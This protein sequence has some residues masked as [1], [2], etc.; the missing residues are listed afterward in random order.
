[1]W[2]E[3]F[4]RLKQSASKNKY[5]I[6]NSFTIDVAVIFVENY[7]K[8][9]NKIKKISH[10]IKQLKKQISIEFHQ[11][12]NRWNYQAANK[13]SSHREWDHHI[14]LK[15]EVVSLVKKTY[16]LSR[17]QTQMIKQ[18][19]DEM[20]EKDFIRF[21]KFDY[22]ILVLIIKKL[23]EDLRVCVNYRALN[24]L[25]IKNRNASSLIR[26]TLTR[27]C[28]IRIYSKFDIIAAFNEVRM[29]E[30]DEKKIVFLTR[31]D[32]FEY[33]VMSFE[34][35]NAFE[36]FQSFINNT[37]REYLNDFYFNYLDD[38]L[39]FSNFKKEHI[40]HVRKVLKRLKEINLFLNIDKCEFFVISVKYLDLIITIDDIKMNSQKIETIVNWK[41]SKCVK[42]VQI[43][44]DF[45]NFYRKF[46]FD[47]FRLAAS[48]SKL[49]KITEI[50]F[51]YSWNLEN[52]EKAIFRTLKLVFIIV[53]ILQ[54]FNSNLKTWIETDVFD[55]IVVAILSQRDIDEQL[56]SV[57]YMS[58]KMSSVECNYEIYDKKL[59]AIVK[60]FEKWKSEC[61]ETSIEDSVKI[62]IDHKNLEHF[63]SFKQLNRRQTKWTE[64]LAKFNFKIAYRSNVQR[65]K[66]DNLTRRSQDL[67][68]N[69]NDERQQYN[70]RILLKAHYLKSEVRKAIEM[71]LA[72]MNER[73]ETVASLAVML[74]DLSEKKFETDEKSTVESSA[75]RHLEDDSIEEKSTEEFSIDTFTAQS[76]IMT[77]IIVVYSNDDN[78]QKIIEVKRQEL[79][80]ISADII[81]TEI[82]LKFDDCEIRKNDLLWIKNRL[83]VLEDEELH[84]V[85]LKQFHDAS[86]SDHADR[87]ITYD[88]L[89]THYYWFRML[90]TIFRYVKSCTQCK[91]IKTY[92]QDKQDLLKSLSI[93]ERYFQNISVDFITSLF[94]CTRYDRVYKHIMIVIDRLS[95]KKKFISLKSLEMK[96]V[97]QVFLKWIW[98][99][100]D[101]SDSIVSNRKTQFISHFWRRLCERINIKSKLST[102]WHFEIDDQIENVN[103]DLKVYLRVYVNFNQ[104]NWIN[105][106]SIVE[107]EV[108]FVINSSTDMT[109]FLATKEYLSKS[110][111]KSLTLITDNVI[112]KREM[113]DVDKFI[114]HQEKLREFLRNELI[115]TQVKQEEQINKRRHVVSEL[116][117]RNKVMLDSRYISIIRSNRE[118]NYKNLDS[119][120]I[121]RA[122][123]NSV[124]ELNLS[125]SMK[126]VFSVFHLWLL[127]LKDDDSLSKQE[128][129]EFD[130]IATDV[131]DNELW[132][133]EKILKFKIDMR[134]ID[135][136]SQQRDA[137]DCLYYYV[138]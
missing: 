38:I 82:R 90:H 126:R 80:R 1:M 138:K 104:N 66:S 13:L 136:E 29:R 42:N 52:S 59:L 71:T 74:Y 4:E 53:L 105:L 125:K 14:D 87:A 130:L 124:Y 88:R 73:E 2:S 133:T 99:E 39:I 18:Y 102:V 10:T 92:R 78:L 54:H 49:T 127:H 33:V 27:L 112:Q 68:E 41:S 98:R 122:I 40:E 34:L 46:I 116:R 75:E 114:Q 35:C 83:Y 85:I 57:I 70:H 86:I 63:M 28:A 47:Y 79:R 25:I 101:Y 12:I 20:L 61:V 5:L 115:W 15:S 91:R 81:K 67:S 118:L 135:F 72:L 94:T 48:L 109:L 95:K 62:L 32:L 64:F 120:E 131:E 100:K 137:K 30:K 77:R 76:D 19:I 16:V 44:L 96:V 23:E 7:E 111:L 22:A 17:E 36:I 132:K 60:A 45:V 69:N 56:H 89:S 58:K 121:V 50:D 108:N 9:F 134:M 6:D 11:F 51:A 106:L 21:S 128:N 43:F 97:I 8:F 103:V 26:E 37:L 110:D 129:H 117:M 55:W 119:F 84:R 31:Y 65:T 24:A 3:K 113:K 107:F 93:L 123:N